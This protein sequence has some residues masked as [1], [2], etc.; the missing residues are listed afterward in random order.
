MINPNLIRAAI[1]AKLQA[2]TAL[3][4]WLTARSASSE[5]RES[6]WQGVTFVYPAIRIDLLPQTEDGNPPCYSNQPFN[7]FAFTEGDS[8]AECGDLLILLDAA[9]IRNQIVGTGFTTGLITSLGSIP[10]NRTSERVWQATG[11]YQMNIFG[12]I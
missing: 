6:Q 7:A 5:I 10:P 1:I 12:G 9:L 2:D 8:S 11:Q 4:A 3:A